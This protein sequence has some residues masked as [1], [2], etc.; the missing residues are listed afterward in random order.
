M[1]I[2]LTYFDFSGS[3]GEE[4][5]LALHLAGLEFTDDRV[6]G[7]AWGPRKA[8]TPW[9]AMPV[10]EVD[11]KQLGQSNAILGWI[12]RTR[13][14]LPTDPWEAAR[15]EAVMSA[16]EDLRHSFQ[17]ALRE[18]DPVLKQQAREAFAAGYLQT[19]A[20]HLEA[21]IAGPFFGG[22]AIS[23][24][25]IKIHICVNWFASGVVDHIEP[26]VFDGFPKLMALHAAVAAHPRVVDWRAR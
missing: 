7:P 2:K 4:C 16:A 15:H 13:G 9:G 12:G 1:S 23:V 5:R 8:S 20:A 11:G 17:P 18:K 3:R 24:A 10:L 22:A 19:W 26:T 21:Q 6:P 14:L 25:D